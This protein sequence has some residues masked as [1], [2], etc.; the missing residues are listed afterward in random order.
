[1]A[2]R[3]R[4][5]KKRRKHWTPAALVAVLAPLVPG[6][7]FATVCRSCVICTLAPLWQSGGRAIHVRCA[8]C[9]RV[10]RWFLR[11]A[12]AFTVLH[13]CAHLPLVFQRPSS[14]RFHQQKGLIGFFGQLPTF[15]QREKCQ[16][17]DK[18]IV[19]FIWRGVLA[20]LR[21]RFKWPI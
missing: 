7:I 5:E 6:M 8:A 2:K 17:L 3:T 11:S 13:L 21:T 18:K 15:F 12:P 16:T 14:T 10:S 19:G 1:M 4:A 9:C 20:E